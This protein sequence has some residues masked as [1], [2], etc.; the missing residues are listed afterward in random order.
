MRRLIAA[1]VLI[2]VAVAVT[3]WTS[4]LFN[5]EM[6]RFEKSLNELIDI[7]DRCT[8]K[9]LAEQAEKIVLRWNETADMLRSIVL[10]NGID[11]LGRN[12]SSLLQII[13]HSDREEMKIKCIE[14]ITLIKNLK[15]CEKISFEN[16][17]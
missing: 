14:A 10:H 16:V 15:D 17:L 13:E 11:E 2:A 5:K 3:G 1:I 6:N 7:S 12:I 4:H 9:T 8:D